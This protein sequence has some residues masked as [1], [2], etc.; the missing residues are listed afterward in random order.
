MEEISLESNTNMKDDPRSIDVAIDNCKTN[1]TYH[2]RQ[3]LF[4]RIAL[5]A[6]VVFF[7]G[8]QITYY[9]VLKNNTSVL[10]EQIEKYDDAEAYFAA[11]I[12][13]YDKK[14]FDLDSLSKEVNAFINEYY[15]SDESYPSDLFHPISRAAPLYTY[16]ERVTEIYDML[17]SKNHDFD[18]LA[19]E[20]IRLDSTFKSITQIDS[21]S[22]QNLYALIYRNTTEENFLRLNYLLS[23]WISYDSVINT[24]IPL[25]DYLPFMVEQVDTDTLSVKNAIQRINDIDLNIKA[26]TFK[27]PETTQYIIYGC[28]FVV[29]GLLTSFYRLH[30]KEV[31]KNEQILVGFYR[32][33]IAANNSSTGF[34]DYVKY[35]LSKDAFTFGDKKTTDQIESP[36]PGHPSSDLSTAVINKLIE[37]LDIK[38]LTGGKTK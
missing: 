38:D 9:L 33:R 18:L 25:F 32:I 5:I 10:S 31:T 29:F 4:Y 14:F 8:A 16:H 27:V 36:I 21:I 35:F 7:I 13:A 11:Y 24:Y 22:S 6:F 12:E 23:D 37:K 19:N 1:I 3:S 15:S 26:M 20:L 2:K 34:D 28:F 17:H 30:L